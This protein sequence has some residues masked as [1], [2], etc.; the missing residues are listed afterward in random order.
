MAGDQDE[1]E[2]AGTPLPAPQRGGQRLALS[3]CSSPM[4]GRVPC[5]PAQ[6]TW[7]PA[8]GSAHSPPPPWPRGARPQG[9]G[10]VWPAQSHPPLLKRS[11]E[12]GCLLTSP[13]RTRML[14]P[15]TATWL[16]GGCPCI[17]GILDLRS[18]LLASPQGTACVREGWGAQGHLKVSSPGT[19]FSIHSSVKPS[20][21]SEPTRHE[22]V[23][24]TPAPLLVAAGQGGIVQNPDA[25]CPYPDGQKP[26]VGLRVGSEPPCLSGPP[27]CRDHR[28][29]RDAPVSV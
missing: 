3:L 10:C 8:Q 16:A 12:V 19:H 15:Q 11:Y 17:L 2:E 13:T 21:G 28:Q 29:D 5:R 4:R 27:F 22:P 18:P 6:D 23:P 26:L 24:R 7:V 1:A 20:D 14:G 9:Q 25:A